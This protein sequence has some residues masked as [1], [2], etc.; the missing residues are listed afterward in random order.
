MAN[1][2]GDEEGIAT[3]RK[4]RKSEDPVVKVY[5]DN[6]ASLAA[7]L[8]PGR[9]LYF[10]DYEQQLKKKLNNQKMFSVCRDVASQSWKIELFIT[11]T[12]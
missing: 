3:L 10:S 4:L 8:E 5:C 2:I 6:L 9:K 11:P 1:M 7:N 12:T